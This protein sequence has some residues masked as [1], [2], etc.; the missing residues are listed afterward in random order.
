MLTLSESA[1]TRRLK[2]TRTNNQ[3]QILFTHHLRSPNYPK[4]LQRTSLS[5]AAHVL[6]CTR[7]HVHSYL[8]IEETLIS[9]LA[10]CLFLTN[11]HCC[12]ILWANFTNRTWH[13][14]AV[15]TRFWRSPPPP[16]PHFL[17]LLACT[18]ASI[19]SHSLDL[20]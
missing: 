5:L 14:L 4:T 10:V 17:F 6:L 19:V 2:D 20:S 11:R 12:E 1:K 13:F 9:G 15:F 8:F 7:A 3:P 16:P 18:P